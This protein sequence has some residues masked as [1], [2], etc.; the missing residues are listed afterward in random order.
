M[1]YFYNFKP[2][3]IFSCIFNKSDILELKTFGN[4]KDIIVTRPDKGWGV[5]IVVRCVAI[6]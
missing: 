1:K 6:Y 4:N 5:V 3:K 2:Y